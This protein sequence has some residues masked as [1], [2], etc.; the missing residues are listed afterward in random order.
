M[1][2]ADLSRA[3]KAHVPPPWQELSDGAAGSRVTACG[4]HRDKKAEN[5]KLSKNLSR[6]VRS[7]E[8]G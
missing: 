3:W 8:L 7:F 4:G 1:L 2:A 6:R 5:E